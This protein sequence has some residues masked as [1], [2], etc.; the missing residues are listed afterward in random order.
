MKPQEFSMYKSKVALLILGL[1]LNGC[2]NPVNPP[3]D[4]PELSVFPT[5]LN[6]VTQKH[7]LVLI[8]QTLTLVL[9][10]GVRVTIKLISVTP[11]AGN[12]Y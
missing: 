9:C 12:Y 11:V 5:S 1:L 10:N 2:R 4:D 7:H 8:L 3:S 6:L